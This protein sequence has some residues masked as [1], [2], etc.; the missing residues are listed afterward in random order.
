MNKYR[1]Q[2]WKDS[3]AFEKGIAGARLQKHRTLV[4]SRHCLHVLG[5]VLKSGS[6]QSILKWKLV[7][8]TM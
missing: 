8:E 1:S 7:Q 5:T 4:E 3:L 6:R 2:S